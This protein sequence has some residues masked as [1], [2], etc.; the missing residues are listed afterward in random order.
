MSGAISIEKVQETRGR[1][2][3]RIDCVEGEA[4]LV[5]TPR[6]AGLISA[7]HTEA[8]ASMRGAGAAAALIDYLIA[9]ARAEGFKIAPLCP[10]AKGPLTD[11]LR[12]F[13][14]GRISNSTGAG[15]SRHAQQR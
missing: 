10:Y 2:V 6:G 13:P 9:D 8:P 15:D 11:S 3:A 14:W 5:F 7:D 1:Y 4:E 12:G